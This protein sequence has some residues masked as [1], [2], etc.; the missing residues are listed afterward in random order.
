LFSHYGTEH[1][2]GRKIPNLNAEHCTA[3][4]NVHDEFNKV[5][6]LTSSFHLTFSKVL[7]MSSKEV[8]PINSHNIKPQ[9]GGL[10]PLI[11]PNRFFITNSSHLW[12]LVLGF[13]NR[14]Y[15]LDRIAEILTE[16][17]SKVVREINR[18]Q[19]NQNVM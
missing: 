16:A 12:C 13:T 1:C 11:S 19:I 17:R 10:F 18:A 8:D 7:K 3:L 2:N 14:Y 6:L 5:N 4:L 15:L 9:R